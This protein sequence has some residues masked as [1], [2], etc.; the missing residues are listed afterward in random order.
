MNTSVSGGP[1]SRPMQ[2]VLWAE[3]SV[4]E[5]RVLASTAGADRSPVCR[6]AEVHVFAQ[7]LNVIAGPSDT[8]KTFIAQCIDY[9]LGAGSEPKE[10]PEA[11]QY[12]LVVLEIESNGRAYVLQRSL[13]GGDVRLTTGGESERLLSAKHQPNDEDTVSE[14]LLGL[15][16]LNGKKV[17]TN[18]QGKTRS[19]SF[20]DIAR[21]ILIDEE[22]VISSASPVLTGQYTTATAE[23]GVFRLLLTGTDDS[24][25]VARE[26]P[27]VAK[28]AAR[29]KA[30]VLELLPFNEHAY[31]W[32]RAG[33]GDG[34]PCR[35]TPGPTFATA[36]G[37]R[38]GLCGAGQRA[39]QRSQAGRTA[40]YRLDAP[41][42]GRS[43]EVTML[44]ELQEAV[45]AF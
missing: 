15:S 42:A 24:S 30:E 26:D 19:L 14:F 3:E 25:V 29:R 1:S 4:V 21:L 9:V 27:K 43:L 41:P 35:G 44:E 8:G 32:P 38:Y 23:G 13:R 17:R 39:G 16:G 6:G 31:R 45:W 12:T 11:A 18:Q 34:R 22:S 5:G 10:I 28:G 36:G 33:R 7:G 2:S 20:R 37:V 40:S